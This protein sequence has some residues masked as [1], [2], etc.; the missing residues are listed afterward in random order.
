MVIMN[1]KENT[2]TK[3]DLMDESY[4][5]IHGEKKIWPKLK[6]K[7]EPTNQPTNRPTNQ[8]SVD[9]NLHIHMGEKRK[10]NWK[11]SGF[12]LLLTCVCVR[13][14]EYCVIGCCCCCCRAGI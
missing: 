11:E 14:S 8:P 7:R 2:E 1:E 4:K 5:C 3:T 13:V 9:H 10:K 6:K 12:L